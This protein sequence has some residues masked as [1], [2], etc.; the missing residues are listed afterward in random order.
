MVVFSDIINMDF[1]PVIGK[2]H[3]LWQ[4]RLHLCIASHAV[5]DVGE[6]GLL[7]T[8]PFHQRQTLLQTEVGVVLL[9]T[10]HIQ[11]QH[12]EPVQLLQLLFGDEAGKKLMMRL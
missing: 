11:H 5:A 1:Q 3:V 12:L 2:M 4:C 8:Q 7:R 10:Q 9:L 6:K